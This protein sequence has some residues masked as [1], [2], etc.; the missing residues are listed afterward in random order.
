M[1]FRSDLYEMLLSMYWENNSVVQLCLSSASC[2]FM[3]T[4]LVILLAVKHDSPP[5]SSFTLIIHIT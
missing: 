5:P 4:I 1:F 3:Q 2:L